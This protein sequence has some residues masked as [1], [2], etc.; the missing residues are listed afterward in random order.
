MTTLTRNKRKNA[1]PVV[2]LLLGWGLF[3]APANSL[4]AET[5]KTLESFMDDSIEERL[6][7]GGWDFRADITEFRP[8]F[9]L[10][11][12]AQNIIRQQSLFLLGSRYYQQGKYEDAIQAFRNATEYGPE[13]PKITLSLARC[14]LKLDDPD[15][16]IKLTDK[17]LLKNPDYV[18]AWMV[19]AEAHRKKRNLQGAIA[20]LE[21][22]RVRQPKNITVLEELGSVYERGSYW[23]KVIDV[24]TEL[25]T[26]RPRDLR[27]LFFLSYAHQINGNSEK[28]IYYID[29]AIS[30]FPSNDQLHQSKIRFL[31][32]TNQIAAYREALH[33]AI[34]EVPQPDDFIDMLR[35]LVEQTGVADAMAQ[36][37]RKIVSEYPHKVN[38]KLKLAEELAKLNRTKQALRIYREIVEQYDNRSDAHYGLAKTLMKLARFDEALEELKKAQESSPFEAEHYLEIGRLYIRRAEYQSAADFLKR[39]LTLQPGSLELSMALGSALRDAGRLPESVSVLEKRLETHPSDPRLYHEHGMT[40]RRQRRHVASLNSFRKAAELQPQSWRSL[41]ELSNALFYAGQTDEAAEK[42]EDTLEQFPLHALANESEQILFANTLMNVALLHE[43]PDLA[44]LVLQTAS[45]NPASSPYVVPGL[46]PLAADY[47]KAFGM[48]KEALK[49]ARESVVRMTSEEQPRV[50]GVLMTALGRSRDAIK[51]LREAEELE[52]DSLYIKRALLSAVEKSGSSTDLRILFKDFKEKYGDEMPLGLEILY[53]RGMYNL[54][55][56]DEAI[57]LLKQIIER[58]DLTNGQQVETYRTLGDLIG[59]QGKIE[60]AREMYENALDL[61]PDDVLSLNNYGYLLAQ[62]SIELDYAEQLLKRALNFQPN[63]GYILDSLGWV[64]YQKLEFERAI[65][66]IEAAL[67][68]ESTNAEL[69]DHLGD[70]YRSIGNE[71][72]ALMYWRRALLLDPEND[73]VR[74]KIERASGSSTMTSSTSKMNPSGTSTK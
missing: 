1:S 49:L 8:D 27:S 50:E 61:N 43:R 14:E 20:A 74:E 59:Q 16:A 2:I 40:L 55:N 60:E 36:E 15:Q 29:E 25:V 69:A 28:A 73:K 64:Y 35:N 6:L 19:Q 45:D 68:R 58:D 10:P 37:L 12:E 22:A 7:E 48:Q 46:L 9:E 26:L 13:D 18:E 31:A 42:F 65:E 70:A 51:A 17:I 54:G 57:A 4:R 38:V 24:Y 52:P 71:E 23:E 34:A 56:E 72:L 30:R 62:E 3:I 47:L 5:N 63:A 67:E 11:G 21:A 33:D 39:G 41:S 32:Q 44:L 53:A 66:L